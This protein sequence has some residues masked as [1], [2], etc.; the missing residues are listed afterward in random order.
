MNHVGYPTYNLCST[1]LLPLTLM[2]VLQFREKDLTFAMIMAEWKSKRSE[3][4]KKLATG[5]L[6]KIIIHCLH[7][8]VL[9]E[10][11]KAGMS[12]TCSSFCFAHALC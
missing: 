7:Q 3:K 9:K 11:F 10:K 6:D 12:S 5:Y 2:R 4:T 8:G 1:T